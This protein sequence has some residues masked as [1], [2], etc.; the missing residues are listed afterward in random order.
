MI[1]DA[2][3][4]VLAEHKCGL[5]VQDIAGAVAVLLGE[6]IPPSSIKS[7]LW[8]EARSDSGRLER[9]GRGRYRLRLPNA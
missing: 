1:R 2:I 6:P 9:V 8:R 4:V 5:R 7:C 3:T